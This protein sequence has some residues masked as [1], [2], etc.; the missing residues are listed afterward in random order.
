MRDWLLDGGALVV[1]WILVR[2][3][4]G[5]ALGGRPL[6][7][8]RTVRALTSLHEL[9]RRPSERGRAP[10]HRP[11]EQVGPDVRRLHCAF[12]RGGMRFA[13]Y[14]GCRLAYDGVLAEAAEILEIIHLLDVLPPGA[15][16]DHER[17]RI[18]CL[19]ERAGLSPWPD[20]A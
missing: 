16:R 18:E 7:E 6:H 1:V 13:K 4:F 20:A 2:T 12:N 3:M 17:E 11:I 8:W 15:E 9:V 10:L 19:L 5:S 14:E